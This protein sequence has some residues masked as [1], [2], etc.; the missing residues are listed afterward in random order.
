MK[1]VRSP[2]IFKDSAARMT[3]YCADVFERLD[4]IGYGNFT[5]DNRKYTSKLYFER[6]KPPALNVAMKERVK[7]EPG[8]EKNFGH[9][10]DV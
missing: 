3:T 8:Q 1:E 4:E 5:S 6:I 9:S 10:L 7:V 2:S